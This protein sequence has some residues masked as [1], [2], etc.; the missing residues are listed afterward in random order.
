MSTSTQTIAK[1]TFS[2]GGVVGGSFADGNYKLNVLSSQIT[3]LAG[4]FLDGDNNGTQ[5][6]DAILNF[7]RYFGDSNGDRRVDIADFGLFSTSY[8]LHTGQTGFLAYLDF[9]NDGTI[10]I[11]DFGQFAIRMF[12]M[13]P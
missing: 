12:T 3:D 5:G 6:G 13:L 2:G 10:D 4:Q 1:L 9:N 11:V 7:F 8:G